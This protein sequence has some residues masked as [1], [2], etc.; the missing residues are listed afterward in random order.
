MEKRNINNK[1]QQLND[2]LDSR[3]Y[4]KSINIRNTE[5]NTMNINM[6]N[7]S[8]HS[9]HSLNSISNKDQQIFNKCILNEKVNS[10][11]S[12]DSLLEEEKECKYCL[13]NDR[14]NNL[15]YPCNCYGTMKYVHPKCLSDWI[16]VKNDK[17]IFDY[18]YTC[19]VCK[20]NIIYK[21]KYK[22]GFFKTILIII[23][24]IF[25]QRKYCYTSL[26]HSLMFI[27]LFKRTKLLIH[28]FLRFIHTKKY[29]NI[30]HNIL[31]SISILLMI[32][33]CIIY[34]KNIFLKERGVKIIFENN[35]NNHS[36]T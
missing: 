1:Q 8:F 22:Y 33:D 9:L 35:K 11:D 10:H 21:K 30:T 32:Y 23:Y 28:D 2:N 3:D 17:E 6:L 14:I 24:N 19:E 16:Q 29:L 4:D 15:V 20:Y 7:S 36:S 34:Y 31:I 13:I 26:C 12:K 25:T 27:F 18:S 5:N